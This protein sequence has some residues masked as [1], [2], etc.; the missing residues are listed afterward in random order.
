[1]SCNCKDCQI[2]KLVFQKWELTYQCKILTAENRTLNDIIK[3]LEKENIDL[4]EKLAFQ[5]VPQKEN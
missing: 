3:K 2:K 5:T 4:T 1:M